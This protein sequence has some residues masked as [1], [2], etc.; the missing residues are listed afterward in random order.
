M[1]QGPTDHHKRIYRVRYS[2]AD[3]DG[4]LGN[5]QNMGVVMALQFVVFVPN[6]H[7]YLADN[8][9][10]VLGQIPGKHS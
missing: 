6:E 1:K 7:L 9:Y 3:L 8:G 5:G 2:L 10:L 4:I